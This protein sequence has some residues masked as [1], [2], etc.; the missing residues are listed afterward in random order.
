[1]AENSYIVRFIRDNQDNWRSLLEEKRIKVKEENGFAIFNYDILADFSDPVVQEARG[2]II[3]LKDLNVVCW[4]FRKFGNS[5]ESYADD[6]DWNSARVQE[7][8]DGSIMKLWYDRNTSKWIL[9][10]NSCIYAK[11]ARLQTGTTLYALFKESENYHVLEENLGRLDTGH[12]YIFELVSPMNQIVIRYNTTKI[13][14]IGTRDN[15]TGEEYCEDIDIERPHEYPLKSLTECIN[16]VKEL[17]KKD[18]PDNEGFV[19]VDKNWHRIKIKSPEYLI[20]H[21]AVNNGIITKER[22]F[23]ILTSDGLD[24]DS[25]FEAASDHAVKAVRYYKARLEEEEHNAMKTMDYARCMESEGLSRKEIA[26]SLKNNKYSMFAF[27]A[28][29]AKESN[30]DIIRRYRK[31]LLNYI[32]DF[33]YL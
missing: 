2:I 18:Y 14:H 21:H 23:E 11:D 29:G 7:K 24:L 27:K 28:L 26:L 1:M 5:H 10:S 33:V 15:V 16:A 22:A 32:D 31:K 8:V 13:Y 9:S 17:N 3:Q 30:E 12:T 20:Y 6:I 19:V 4:P 25:F